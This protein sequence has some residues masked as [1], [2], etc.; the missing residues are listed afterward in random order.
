MRNVG[1]FITLILFAVLAVLKLTGV[2]PWSWWII[3]APL[4]IP[5]IVAI[6]VVFIYICIE[7]YYSKR[8]NV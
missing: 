8:D 3:T 5:F 6:I 7:I 4:W 2:L 1:F